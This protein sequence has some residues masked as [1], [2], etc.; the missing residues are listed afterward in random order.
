MQAIKAREIDPDHETEMKGS[1]VEDYRTID[2]DVKCYAD[3]DK[4]TPEAR[5]R[6]GKKL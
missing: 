2:L 1:S 3:Y 5:Y 4:S 6:S